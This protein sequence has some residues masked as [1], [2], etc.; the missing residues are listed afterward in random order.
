SHPF[1][2][3]VPTWSVVPMIVLAAVATVIA[4]QAVISGAFSL[5]RQA[6]QLGMSPPIT[7]RQTSSA[8]IGQ[9]YVPLVNWLLLLAAVLL[10]AGFGSSSDLAGAYGVAVSTTM[11][12][13][14]T[15]TLLVATRCW[16]WRWITAGTLTA[17]FLAV[18]LGFFGANLL[19]IWQGGWI[20]LVIA[21]VVLTMFV[22]WPRGRKLLAT[23]LGD[24]S[25]PVDL[26]L[27]SLT[28]PNAP[29]RIPGIGVFLTSPGPGVPRSML[30]HLKLNRVLNET[31]I[32][33]TAVTEEVPRLR[34]RDRVE[35]EP[36]GAGLFRVRAHYGFMESPD[37]PHALRLCW[38]RGLI[39][40]VTPETTTYYLGRATLVPSRRPSMP[41]WQRALFMFMA[42][43][44][45]R[46]TVYYTLPPGRTI[47]LGI[48]IDI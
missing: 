45:Q 31:V 7:I 43:N 8:E 41:R 46:A 3:L 24:G 14:T 33:L 9:I 44:A 36:L 6:V 47:E 28:G 40:P 5:T 27:H 11:V 20:P 15:L 12:I 35:V 4:S 23:K 18:D 26:F 22:T 1:Y 2:A 17:A 38:V 10:V 39:P 25:L 13:T 29:R 32:L 30:H 34:S 19:K 21:G 37:I 48:Q 16:R 42:R